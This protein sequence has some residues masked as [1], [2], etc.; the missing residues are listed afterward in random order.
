M[1]TIK[2][3]Y[4]QLFNFFWEIVKI[5]RKE[6]WVGITIDRNQVHRKVY[7]IYIEMRLGVTGYTPVFTTK[8]CCS[9]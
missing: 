3:M 9:E 2:N 4:Q 7:E 1:T 5:V 8:S 6:L